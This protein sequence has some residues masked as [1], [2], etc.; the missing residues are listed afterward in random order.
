V[1][2]PVDPSNDWQIVEGLEDVTFYQKLSEG[3]TFDI[4]IPTKAKRMPL[5]EQETSGDRQLAVFGVT[6]H[7]WKNLLQGREPKY[8]DKIV[9][10][11]NTVYFIH[12]D[13]DVVSLITR[14]RCVCL[15]VP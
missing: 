7:L 1:T 2:I 8:G 14:Y 4:G 13:V 9:A 6:I 15:R 12:R 10:R 11:D 3:N 5:N